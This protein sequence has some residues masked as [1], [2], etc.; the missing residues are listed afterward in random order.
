M[1]S[2]TRSQ[3]FDDRAFP[4]VRSRLWNSLPARR[5][6]SSNADCFFSERLKTIISFPDHFLPNCFRFSVLYTV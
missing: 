4:V 6:L 5:H 1:S 3:C 2:K